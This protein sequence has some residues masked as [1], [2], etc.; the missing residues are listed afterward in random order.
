MVL[1]PAT[2]DKF[3][4]V[5]S[6]GTA[7]TMSA[8]GYLIGG[9]S[10]QV[11]STTNWPTDTKVIFAIDRA[12]VVNGVEERIAGTYNEFEGIVTGANTIA[13]LVKRLGNNQNYPAGSLTRIYIP[14]AATRENDTVD[15]LNQDHN[16]KG[17]HKSLTDDNDNEWLERGQVASAV[18]HVKTTNAIT[19]TAPKLQASG[20]DAN[21]NLEILPKG[22]GLVKVDGSAPRQFFALYNFIESGCVWA[23]LGY[24]SNLNAGMSAGVVWIAG[25]RLTVAAV[26]TRGFTAS[27]DTYI[28]Y[29]DNNDGTAKIVYSEVTNNAA[30]PAIPNSLADATNI[31]GGI[32]VSGANIANVGAVN[33]GEED[34]VL[35]IVSGT[36]YAV[37]DSLGNLL[38][39]RDP[40]RKLLGYRQL[41]ASFPTNS[42]TPVAV[43]ALI[44]PFIV[45]SLGRKIK[46]TVVLPAP[47]NSTSGGGFDTKIYDGLVGVG[48]SIS[49]GTRERGAGIMASSLMAEVIKTP[50]VVSKTYAASFQSLNGGTSDVN[51]V[52]ISPAFIKIELE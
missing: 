37:T 16:G 23:G 47:Y 51:G 11:G 32:I 2:T 34:K 41:T 10:I 45:P 50:T 14:V 5:G 12:A 13:S 52:A 46:A 27:K 39:P 3:T 26:A 28:D 36:A 31:R 4:K 8:P 33:Q 38:A 6:P 21:V 48:S 44:V 18:N 43:P 30:S 9:T 7:T 25:R 1:I 29:Q 22:T 19:G 24:G 42:A 40:S 20:D 17:N 15:G 35:P 49:N